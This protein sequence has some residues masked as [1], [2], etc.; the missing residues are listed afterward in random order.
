MQFK[1][2]KAVRRSICLLSPHPTITGGWCFVVVRVGRV[3]SINGVGL[4]ARS[5]GDSDVDV[6]FGLLGYCSGVFRTPRLRSINGFLG[7]CA[8]PA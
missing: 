8:L 5:L 4:F 1:V 6:V 7:S 2:F 3:H